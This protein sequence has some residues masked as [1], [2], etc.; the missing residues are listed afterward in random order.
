MRTDVADC[1]GPA[2]VFSSRGSASIE[3]VENHFSASN[4][5]Y[6]AI[7]KSGRIDD[8]KFAYHYLKSHIRLI[9][10]GFRGMVNNR[11]PKEFLE[12]IELPANYES[13]SYKELANSIFDKGE[14]AR[15]KHEEFQTM[16]NALHRSVFLDTFGDPM[17]NPKKFEV[18]RVGLHLSRERSPPIYGSFRAMPNRIE[19][20]AKGIPVWGADNVQSIR[21]N[22]RIKKFVSE[23]K[24][25]ELH[26]F[27][28]CSGD[29]LISRTETDFRMCVARPKIEHSI[30]EPYLV[31]V[32]LNSKSLTA[33]YF[34]ALFS[35][36]PNRIRTLT[37]YKKQRTPFYL[38]TKVIQSIEIPIPPILLQE[39]YRNLSEKIENLTHH[40]D[41]QF[42]ELN[43]L[44]SSLANRVFRGELKEN[45]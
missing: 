16:V 39:K 4:D 10:K 18:E 19:Y 21:F 24:Y 32:T 9:E 3:Y 1:K 42:I 38:S 7:P 14:I 31:R 41:S 44:L 6:I 27:R 34:V 26:R 29:V 35:L 30:M 13:D 22:D 33:E 11:L 40:S 23:E 36:F 12:R 17:S 25:Y 20:A 5:C 8:A 37:T 15:A 2:L 43:E 28:V 45:W